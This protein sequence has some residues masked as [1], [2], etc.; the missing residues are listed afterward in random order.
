MVLYRQ[1]ATVSPVV[2]AHAKKLK[3]LCLLSNASAT[4]SVEGLLHTVRRA[5]DPETAVR[6]V[7]R[8]VTVTSEILERKWRSTIT[9]LWAAH[10]PHVPLLPQL[11]LASEEV[12][13]V[14]IL[15]DAHAF[16]EEIL[17]QPAQLQE[18]HGELVLAAP[19][20]WR[21]AAA[22]PTL[23]AHGDLPVESEWAYLPLRRLRAVLQALRL[24]RP[25]KGKLVVVRSRY[26]RFR[27]FPAMQQFYVLWHADAYH[28]DW[29]EFAGMWGRF[30]R[31]I[32]DY[33]P[34]LWDLGEHVE[35]GQDVDRVIWSRD[36]LETFAPLWEEEGLLEIGRGQAAILPI[37]QQHALPAILEKFI[38]DDVLQ[39]HGVITA[40]EHEGKTYYTWTAIGSRI[41]AAELTQELPCGLEL[42]SPQYAQVVEVNER[43]Q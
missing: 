41:F 42:L 38:L 19:D 10:H 25:V 29:G 23:R 43:F 30:T 17:C 13:H 39:R 24:V 1:M 36:V 35:A 15:Q 31:V 2:P 22:L 26:E 21:L 28:V 8:C 5:P 6:E 40:S 14:P 32:Q 11:K 37:V 9:S 4:I 20:V 18:E 34:L 33:L 12:S 7:L 27:H 16:L 3:A